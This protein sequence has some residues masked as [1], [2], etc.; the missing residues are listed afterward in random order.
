[1][2]GAGRGGMGGQQIAFCANIF[3]LISFV[4][5]GAVCPGNVEYI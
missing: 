2:S 1:M 5:G 3:S 4:Y